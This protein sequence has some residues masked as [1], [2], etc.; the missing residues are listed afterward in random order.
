MNDALR[1][2][3]R[4]RADIDRG[5]IIVTLPDDRLERADDSDALRLARKLPARR[6]DPRIDIDRRIERSGCS[7]I[8]EEPPGLRFVSE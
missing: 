7:R 3:Y 5:K 6:I 1:A 2:R 4:R 8:L